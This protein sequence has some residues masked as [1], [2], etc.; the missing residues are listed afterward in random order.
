VNLS[1]DLPEIEIDNDIIEVLE[2]LTL[3]Q[4]SC[5][6]TLQSGPHLSSC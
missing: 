1:F 6:L 5:T 4:D 3:V 2:P